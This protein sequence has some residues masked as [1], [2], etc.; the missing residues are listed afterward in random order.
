MRRSTSRRSDS[1]AD[2]DSDSDAG[3]APLVSAIRSSSARS[4]DSMAWARRR[5]FEATLRF[6]TLRKHL[7]AIMAASRMNG[8]GVRSSSVTRR[9]SRPARRIQWSEASMFPVRRAAKAA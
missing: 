2:S 5:P 7:A 3:W 1:D 4:T 8:S 6:S 9:Y